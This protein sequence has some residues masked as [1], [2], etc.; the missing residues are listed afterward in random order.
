MGWRQGLRRPPARGTW[1]VLVAG[2]TAGCAT[3]QPAAD[4]ELAAQVRAMSARQTDLERKVDALEARL[5]ALRAVPAKGAVTPLEPARGVV[6]LVPKDLATVRLAPPARKTAPSIPTNVTIQEPD[7]AKMEHVLAERGARDALDS[8]LQAA[9]SA[10]STGDVERGARMLTSFADRHRRDERAPTA[11]YQAAMGL[12][13]YDDP[14]SAALTFE[15]LADDYPLASEAPEA[16]V[17]LAEC[18]VRLKRPE[19]A[20][21]VYG[22]VT[23]RYPGTASAK[24]AD[25]GLEILKQNEAAGR[26]TTEAERK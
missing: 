8:E 20:R 21:E 13:R 9:M 24:A 23:D 15:R 25:A 19:R 22:R 18:H 12:M 5:E 10:I 7:A 1:A 4:R 2:V 14:Q 3:A 16:M 17:R 6:P 11:L 26:V